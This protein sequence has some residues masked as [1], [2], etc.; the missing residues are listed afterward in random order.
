MR[1]SPQN[2][3]VGDARILPFRGRSAV[4]G[5][6][7]HSRHAEI[8]K[9]PP[10]SRTLLPDASKTRHVLTGLGAWEKA[11]SRIWAYRQK[12]VLL[13]QSDPRPFDRSISR[14]FAECLI[15]NE[16]IPMHGDWIKILA[17][18]LLVHTD[19]VLYI[20]AGPTVRFDVR[21]N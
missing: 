12:V 4:G 1:A 15:V 5:A 20:G 6:L 17:A 19:R 18:E 8:R 14:G 3:V 11:K 9:L 21:E 10:Y 2:S 16:G 13:F 7:G